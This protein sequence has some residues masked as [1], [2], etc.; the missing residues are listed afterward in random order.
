MVR[1]VQQGEDIVITVR[2]KPAAK[3]TGVDKPLDPASRKVWLRRLKHLR[4]KTST[5]KKG[6]TTDQILAEDREER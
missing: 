6:K 3:L 2:G 4:G 5:G 1:L